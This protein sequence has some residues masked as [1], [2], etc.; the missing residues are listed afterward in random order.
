MCNRLTPPIV[1]MC[2][3]VVV[4]AFMSGRVEAA[5]LPEAWVQALAVDPV[6]SSIVYAGT[7]VGIYKTT[8]AGA[9]WARLET[10]LSSPDVTALAIDPTARCTVYAGVD[11]HV[12]NRLIRFF[13]TPVFEIQNS[14]EILLVSTDC[15]ATWTLAANWPG[16]A[17]YDLAFDGAS[18]PTLLAR[19]TV[20]SLSG[21]LPSRVDDVV[22]FTTTATNLVYTDGGGGQLGSESAI[23]ADP[24]DPCVAYVANR[25]GHVW[26]ASGCAP[27]AWTRIAIL[28]APG[29][30]TQARSVAVHP[31]NHSILV[32]TYAQ[33]TTCCTPGGTI[34]RKTDATDWT[35]ALLAPE[36]INTIVFAPGREQVAYAAGNGGI[37]YKSLDEGATWAAGRTIGK[38]VAAL[39]A[40]AAP[41]FRGY[42]GGFGYVQPFGCHAG[43]DTSEAIAADCAFTDPVLGPGSIIIKAA[44]VAELRTRIDRLRGQQALPAAAWSDPTLEAGVTPV[45]ARHVLE[46]RQALADVYAA[47]MLTPPTYTDPD[48]GAG[49]VAKGVHI[50]ELRLAVE[51]VE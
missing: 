8:D 27:F 22:Q 28:E 11:S 36:A 45:R 6:D 40:G 19:V 48:L 38:S 46:L 1:T 30:Q 42:A 31:S 13:P 18:P 23:A 17:V 25:H 15:G 51:R 7:T 4:L 47:S 2:A 5:G 35:I 43:A 12:E 39:A 24:S 41:L 20:N 16:R 9:N 14:T 33:L 32:G 44:H 21:G 3:A 34:H 49:T 26:K 29:R 50:T 37:V 10:S